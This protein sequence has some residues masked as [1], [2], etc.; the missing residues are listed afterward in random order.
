MN[1]K[2]TVDWMFHQLPMYQ[3]EGKR[4]YKSDL[5]NIIALSDYLNN[6]EKKFKT[7]HVAGTNGKGS[8]SHML[9]S[10]LQEAGFKVGLY[11][12]PHLIDFR[13]RIKINGRCINKQFVIGFIKSNRSFFESNRLS[14]FEMT[15]GMAFDYF[16]KKKVDFAVVEVGLGGRLDSTNII[17]PELSIITNIGFDHME[18]LGNSLKEIASEKAGIIKTNTPIV[19]GETQA[20]VKDVFIDKAR[21]EHAP[22]TFADQQKLIKTYSI[23]LKGDYQ[24]RNLKTTVSAIQALR[25][26]GYVITE[27]AIRDG[28]NK[29]VQNTSLFGRWQI[30]RKNPKII[31]DT[32]HN[33]E[34]LELVMRQLKKESFEDLHLVLGSVK[35]KNLKSIIDLFPKKANYYFCKANVVRSRNAEEMATFFN[36][37]GLKGKAYSSV[38]SA[39]ENAIQNA[40]EK[41]VIFVGGSTFVVA[42]AL[43]NFE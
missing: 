12:S 7:V 24:I 41:D 32:A 16:A 26:K 27:G 29:I 11:T 19:I 15:V 43:R 40:N 21:R 17:R 20:E 37:F 6:P 34:G 28:L 4:A 33:R 1:Y 14:F 22:I 13:E 42:E 30:L 10:V 35:E 2:D 8:T 9:A 3:N 31:L 36:R 38:V 18:F 5:H 25:N 39:L 23:D